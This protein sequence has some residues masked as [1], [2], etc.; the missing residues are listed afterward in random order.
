MSAFNTNSLATAAEAIE[1]ARSTEAT[2]V[3]RALSGARYDGRSLGGIGQGVMRAGDHQFIQPLYVSVMQRAGGD[4]VR[5][6]V[7][8][9]GYG[10]RTLRQFD[11]AATELPHRCNMTAP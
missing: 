8:G 4:A 1:R 6:D 5:F 9:T 3:A 7:E 2:A 10:F 11:A